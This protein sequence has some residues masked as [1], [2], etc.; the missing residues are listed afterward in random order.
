MP[1]YQTQY[2]DLAQRCKKANAHKKKLVQGIEKKTKQL[3]DIVCEPDPPGCSG[4]DPSLTMEELAEKCRNANSKKREL[5]ATILED[6]K[7]LLKIA[8]EPDPP[9]CGPSAG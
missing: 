8:C 4:P 7:A 6:V 2:E 3:F 9:G 5:L 1:D